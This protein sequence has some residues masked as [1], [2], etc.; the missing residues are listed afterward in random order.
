MGILFGSS[1]NFHPVSIQSSQING[2]RPSDMSM[3][4]DITDWEVWR[5]KYGK[6]KISKKTHQHYYIVLSVNTE[7]LRDCTVLTSCGGGR[8]LQSRIP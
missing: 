4:S 7:M 6:R 8:V 2:G 3:T 1:G 5:R